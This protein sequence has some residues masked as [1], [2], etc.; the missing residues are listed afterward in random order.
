MIETPLPPVT[1]TPSAPRSPETPERPDARAWRAA[2]AMEASFLSQMLRNTG[3]DA[4]VAGGGGPGADQFASFQRQAL[5]AKM[6]E[7][8][9][10][11]LAESIYDAIVE[12]K[13][14]GHNG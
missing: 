12:R 8:G 13:D 14:D 7:G 4:A 9:G 2:H 1:A 3:L 10:L 5:A 11:G 6:V